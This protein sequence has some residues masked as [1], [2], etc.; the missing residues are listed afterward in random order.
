MSDPVEERDVEKVLAVL[1]DERVQRK[2]ASFLNPVW[3]ANGEITVRVK[4]KEELENGQREK[5]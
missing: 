3:H 2:I 5:G 4:K 1:D